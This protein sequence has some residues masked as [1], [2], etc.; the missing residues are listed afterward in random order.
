MNPSYII[1]PAAGAIIGYFTNWLAIKMLFRPHKQ[2]FIG[3]IKVPFTPGLI[4]KE[5]E[6]I[7]LSLGDTVGNYILTQDV[8]LD[9]LNK[10]DVI[11]SLSS[12]LDKGFNSLKCSCLT[13]DQALSNII[14]SDKDSF[15][16][17]AKAG[18]LTTIESFLLKPNF[19]DDINAIIYNKVY[20]L[21]STDIKELPTDKLLEVLRAAIES[22]TKDIAQKGILRNVIEKS[23]WEFLLNLKDDE[24][25]LCAIASYSSVQEA[26][27]YLSIKTPAI[28]NALISLTENPE[29]EK[30]IKAKII[31]IIQNFAGPFM[32]MFINAD[33]IYVRLIE[34]LT[35]YINDPENM[36]EIEHAVSLIVD[37]AMD[38]TVGEVCGLI[39]GEM[40]EVTINKAVGFIIEEITKTETIDTLMAKLSSYIAEHENNSILDILNTIDNNTDKNVKNFIDSITNSMFSKATVSF[41]TEVV[42]NQ[43]SR[44][45]EQKIA[46]LTQKVSQN[47]FESFKKSIF[48]IYG[49]SLK[50]VAPKVLTAFNIP[51]IVEE[52]INSFSIQYTEELIL[53]IVNKELQAITAVGGVLGFIIGLLPV[54]IELI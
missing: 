48:A 54:L 11:S 39:T 47:T 50:T 3:K 17:A 32:G 7:A 29:V 49:Y 52:R 35:V 36:P 27:D 34:S 20:H 9:Y 22:C 1:T 25:K 46:Y 40:R 23:L 37:K 5:K 42:N 51:K 26:K 13:V 33:D 24:R 2:L 30:L 53:A 15:I 31:G 10:P 45:L 21:L 41:I 4:P 18:A 14:G 12:S 44:L 43:T 16:D 8:M 19:K 28:V 6:R 38:M